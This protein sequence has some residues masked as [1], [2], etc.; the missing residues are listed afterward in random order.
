MDDHAPTSG[1]EGLRERKKRL[2]RQLISDTATEMF[3]ERGFDG[4]RVS[5]VAQRCGVS[6]KTVFNYFPTKESLILDRAED[7]EASVRAA[8]GPGSQASSPIEAA[9]GVLAEDLEQLRENWDVIGSG[10]L[11][12][13]FMDLVDSTPALRAAHRD[14]E[15]HLVQVA[16]EAMAARAGLSPDDPEPQI[17]AVALMGLWRAQQRALNLYS[18]G[19]RT[20]DEFAGAVRADVERA[21]RLVESGLWSFEVMVQGRGTRDQM[22]AAAEAAQAAGRQVATAL[23]QARSLWQQVQAQHKPAPPGGPEA[24]QTPAPASFPNS[25]DLRRAMHDQV[26]ADVLQWKAAQKALRDQYVAAVREQQK[27]MREAARSQRGHHRGR[28]RPC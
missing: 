28:G 3:L 17:A 27:M 20:F 23:R 26:Q 13:R 8:L 9:L 6:E 25:R 16:A 2:T 18:R 4:V 10:A 7:A 22:Q 19:A 1:F 12:H 24:D 14:I 15:E 21:A 5:E 11:F